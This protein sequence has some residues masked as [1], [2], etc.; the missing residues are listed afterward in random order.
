MT[1]EQAVAICKKEYVFHSM[2]ETWMKPH[3]VIEYNTP[4][5]RDYGV[6][7]WGYGGVII[8]VDIISFCDYDG[9]THP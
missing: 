3:T 5:G 8:D 9:N 6:N 7:M 1:K 4:M 2:R